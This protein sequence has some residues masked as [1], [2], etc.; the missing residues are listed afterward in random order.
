MKGTLEQTWQGMKIPW[1]SFDLNSNN[2]IDFND[3]AKDLFNVN[4][5]KDQ[6][7]LSLKLS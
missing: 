7:L 1:I 2:I 6:S 5:K 3:S 4:I